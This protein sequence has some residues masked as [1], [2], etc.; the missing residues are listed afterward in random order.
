M[1]T[2]RDLVENEN[3][4]KLITAK[5]SFDRASGLFDEV[6]S[7]EGAP[8]DIEPVQEEFFNSLADCEKKLERLIGTV[9]YNDLFNPSSVDM[10]NVKERPIT[11]KS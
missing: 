11:S 9:V 1:R 4:G 6:F 7:E 8:C 5:R 10:K 2:V 3:L